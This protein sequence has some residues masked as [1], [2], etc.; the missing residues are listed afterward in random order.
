MKNN[1]QF[2]ALENFCQRHHTLWVRPAKSVTVSTK[3]TGN[4]SPGLR[5]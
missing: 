3:N 5:E 1:G 2:P 4:L